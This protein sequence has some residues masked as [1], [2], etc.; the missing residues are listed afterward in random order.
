LIEGSVAIAPEDTK[1]T[2]DINAK[3]INGNFIFPPNHEQGNYIQKKAF[4]NVCFVPKAV[5]QQRLPNE[6]R[7]I[8]SRLISLKPIILN[9]R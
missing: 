7:S 6:A 5:I 2:T 3:L 8:S 9:R 1:K 4:A